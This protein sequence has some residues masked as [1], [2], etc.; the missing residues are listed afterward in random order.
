MC[1]KD[2]Q[3]LLKR[4]RAHTNAVAVD[5]MNQIVGSGS[6]LIP[7]NDYKNQHTIIQSLVDAYPLIEK[8]NDTVN[9]V[10]VIEPAFPK[11]VLLF[12]WYHTPAVAQHQKGPCLIHRAHGRCVCASYT[13]V[14]PRN[15]CIFVS[16]IY[17]R[18]DQQPILYCVITN[19]SSSATSE[20]S[21]LDP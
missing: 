3:Q 20:R 4:W 19:T 6:S 8:N 15:C 9:D 12:V 1:S 7:S 2:C 14:K 11:Y 13:I 5:L 10:D 16:F 21:L 17:L 18:L